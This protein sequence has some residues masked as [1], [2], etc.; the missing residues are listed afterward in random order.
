MERITGHQQHAPAVF[1]DELRLAA[2]DAANPGPRNCLVHG[3]ERLEL[4]QRR[5][6]GRRQDDFLR[7]RLRHRAG[8]RQPHAMRRLGIVVRGCL[9]GRDAGQK[10]S[11]VELSR[12]DGRRHPMGKQ[13][14]RVERKPQMF[15]L[16][17]EAHRGGAAMHVLPVSLEPFVNVGARKGDV[18]PVGVAREKDAGFLEEL[19]SGR[20][21]VGDRL[22]RCQASELPS[23]VVDPVAPRDTSVVIGCINPS[24]GKNVS[25]A[26]ERRPLVAADEKHLRSSRTVAQHHDRC[27][28]TGI[29]DEGIRGHD[30]QY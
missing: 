21:V 8:R 14:E 11:R 18:S 19:A 27:G 4:A 24:T 2:D 9:I 6:G 22:R 7:L 25:A 26:H 16:D 15:A 20:H 28:G 23:C 30:G 5:P 13:D 29:G 17:G 1:L 10:E 3:R 12:V